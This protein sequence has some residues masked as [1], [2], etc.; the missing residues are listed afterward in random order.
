[1]GDSGGRGRTGSGTARGKVEIRRKQGMVYPATLRLWGCWEVVNA[2][3][4][5]PWVDIVVGVIDKVEGHWRTVALHSRSFE[6]GGRHDREDM[7]FLY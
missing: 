6:V 7:T 1:M 2:L 5:T 4:H 3:I